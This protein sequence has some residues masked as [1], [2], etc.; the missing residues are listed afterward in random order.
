[1]IGWYRFGRI[2]IFER[3]IQRDADGLDLIIPIR[4]SDLIFAIR[5]RS[6]GWGERLEGEDELTGG[7]QFPGEAVL[8]VIDGEPP[9]DGD[10]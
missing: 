10:G 5:S 6:N 7:E 2:C 4:L 1:L 3:W 9:V 8:M